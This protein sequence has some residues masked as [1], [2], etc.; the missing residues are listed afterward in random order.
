MGRE[1]V[2]LTWYHPNSLDPHG[3]QAQP[4]MLC[5]QPDPLTLEHATPL[6]LP[7]YIEDGS[8]VVPPGPFSS[9]LQTGLQL[10]RLSVLQ[11]LTVLIPS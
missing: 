2:I 1:S 4:V 7:L 10:P 3:S 5:H 6:P 11:M 9:D 8:K